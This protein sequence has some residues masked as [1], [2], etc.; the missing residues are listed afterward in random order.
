MSYLTRRSSRENRFRHR[1]RS[2]SRRDS[3]SRA[4]RRLSLAI[5]PDV[6]LWLVAGVLVGGLAFLY[7]RQGTFLHQLTADREAAREELTQLEEINH[8]LAIQVEEGFSFERL[9]RYAT[10]QLGMVVPTK[11]YY[12]RV[13][14]SDV[15]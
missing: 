3:G 2:E 14:A 10:Q 4:R 1:R 9:S 6:A 8:S 11:V 12:V 13:P 15:R 5:P 7:I